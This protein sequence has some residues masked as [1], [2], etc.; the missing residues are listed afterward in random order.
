MRSNNKPLM[1]L[2]ILAL[3]DAHFQVNNTVQVDA[4]LTKLR[5]L[6]EERGSEIDIIV[7]MGDVLHTHARLHVVP[8]NKAVI[9]FQLLSSF[10]PTYVVVGNHDC[11]GNSVFLTPDHWANFL[12]SWANITVVDNVIIEM[13]KGQ[14]VVMCPYVPDGRVIE[15]LDTK[16][17]EWEDA[18]VILSH[19]TIKGANMGNAV[20]QERLLRRWSF[21]TQR[22]S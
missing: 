16:K 14:K 5:A 8:L 10:K 22:H 20:A 18:D 9:Y 1:P 15:A 3:G 4:Y 6:L 7:S 21:K 13:I 12:K 19:V 11:V 2:R 17:G